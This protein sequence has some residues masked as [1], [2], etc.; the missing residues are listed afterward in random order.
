MCIA[1]LEV[2]YA[3]DNDT[4]G[5]LM[6]IDTGEQLAERI[7]QLKASDTVTRIKLFDMSATIEKRTVW[8]VSTPNT[9]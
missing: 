4:E 9:L 1:I 3:S 7:D 2:R 5:T 6:R 8:D